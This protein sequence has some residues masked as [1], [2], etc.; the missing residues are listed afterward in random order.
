M[1]LHAFHEGR[2]RVAVCRELLQ[3]RQGCKKRGQRD[4]GLL[5]KEGAVAEGLPELF[6]QKKARLALAGMQSN[7]L[8]RGGFASAVGAGEAGREGAVIILAHQVPIDLDPDFVN[9]CNN[10]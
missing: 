9:E 8:L 2:K 5:V 6:A 10:M 3:A 4:L 7:G 1:L